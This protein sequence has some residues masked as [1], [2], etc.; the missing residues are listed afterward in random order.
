MSAATVRAWSVRAVGLLLLASFTVFAFGIPFRRTHPGWNDL[1][2]LWTY[3]LV[4]GCAAVL[5][6][7]NRSTDRRVRWAWRLVAIG[8]L[9][10]VGGQVYSTLVVEKMADPPYPSFADALYLAFYLLAYVAVVLL[11]RVWMSRGHASMWLDGVIAGTGAGAL[12]VAFVLAPLLVV[13][14]GHPSQVA[15]NLAYP[16]ADLLLVGMLVGSGA[17]LGLTGDRPMVLFGLGLVCWFV[18]D[19]VY[20]L[21]SAHGTYA[22]GT[23]LDLTWPAGAAAMAAAALVRPGRRSPGSGGVRRRSAAHVFWRTLAL[24]TVFALASLVLLVY[25]QD[26]QLSRVA[27]ILAGACVLAAM[28]R[29]LLTFREIRTLSELVRRQAWTD[30]LTDLPNRRALY[31]RCDDALDRLDD[32]T[33]LSLLL[34]DL[35]RFKEIN[36]SLGHQAGDVLLGLVGPRLLG[37]LGEG[38]LLVRL[39]GDEFAILL[40]GRDPAQAAVVARRVRDALREPFSVDRVSLHVDVSIGVAGAHGPGHSRS[41]LLRRADIAMYEAKSAQSGVGEF[42]SGAGDLADERLRTLEELR[43][44]L[45]VGE[46]V[47]HLQPK[48]SLHTGNVVGVEALVRWQHPDRGLLAP[49]AFLP[50]AER[51]GLQRQLADV[52]IGLALDAC[53]VWW[54]AGRSIPV[55]VNLAAANVHD[56]ELPDKIAAALAQRR[57]PP[58][59]LSVE[60]TENTLMTDP[61][62]ARETLD[63]LRAMGVDVAIDD[64]GTGYSSLAYL[65]QLAVDELKLDRVF[66]SG[67]GTDPEA[68]AIAQHT[69]ALAH[70]LG[71]R[72]VA[73]GIETTEAADLLAELGCDIGQGFHIARPM[74]TVDLIAWLGARAVDAVDRAR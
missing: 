33:W 56:V 1:F 8:L 27:G 72:L 73:E 32:G 64:Y 18:G 23:A 43:R 59:A 34:L 31:R 3:N 70:A 45:Q 19:V 48:T 51:A 17:A 15:T 12:G 29:A 42:T 57:L 52:V 50:L 67:L 38:D 4:F 63:R 26:G 69:V 30:D 16:I 9:L 14:G 6:L 2:D 49:D 68:T 13:S 61:V 40:P 71:L 47:V 65:R 25:G 44:A 74:P 53:A 36:D 5:C 20:L 58:E 10:E 62:R 39:G 46:L 66:T 7:L 21:Q 35:D 22:L 37:L 55:A 11:V 41:D 60:L 28:L 24:P 54:E